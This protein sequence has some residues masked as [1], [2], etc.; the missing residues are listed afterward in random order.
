MTI[1]STEQLELRKVEKRS[2]VTDILMKI[3]ER[4]RGVSFNSIIPKHPKIKVSDERWSE[5]VKLVNDWTN[6]PT[7]DK[8]V[9]LFGPPATG[10]TTLLA[11]IFLR[12]AVKQALFR[13]DHTGHG[14]SPYWV[15]IGHWSEQMANWSNPP[16]LNLDYMNT[17]SFPVHLF[18]DEFDKVTDNPPRRQECLNTFVRIAYA[19]TCPM[20]IATNLTVAEYLGMDLY[21]GRRITEDGDNLMID[22]YNTGL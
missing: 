2:I 17:L 1:T 10:K 9:I 20:F 19:K 22:L 6:G 5:V 8:G 7:I 18:L 3:P 13:V 11:A 16:A 4:H 12:I 14:Y 21:V 15:D